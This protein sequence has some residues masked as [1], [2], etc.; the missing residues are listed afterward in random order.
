MTRILT[1]LEA[2]LTGGRKREPERVWWCWMAFNV[3]NGV[4]LRSASE[5]LPGGAVIEEVRMAGRLTGGGA[6]ADFGVWWYLTS[7]ANPGVGSAIAGDA[8]IDFGQAAGNAAWRSFS[9]Y[10]SEAWELHKTVAGAGLRIA[11]QI[12]G[13]T[14]GGIDVKVGARY[15]MPEV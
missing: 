13:L 12:T 6:S 9:D 11:V 10:P 4:N 5:V 1:N 8:I 2:L 15:R 7:E 14:V 3:P